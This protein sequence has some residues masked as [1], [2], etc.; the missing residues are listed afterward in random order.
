MSSA[1]DLR[2]GFVDRVARSLLVSLVSC[3]WSLASSALSAFGRSVKCGAFRGLIDLDAI[4]NFQ[5]H[6]GCPSL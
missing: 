3:V 5:K 6:F 2:R 4:S 1:T